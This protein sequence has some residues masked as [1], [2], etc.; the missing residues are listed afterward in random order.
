[1]MERKIS[2]AEIALRIEIVKK[3][4]A[5]KSTYTEV[6]PDSV[7]EFLEIVHSEKGATPICVQ[8]PFVKDDTVPELYTIIFD[9]YVGEKRTQELGVAR[10][11]CAGD[12]IVNAKV[13]YN[14]QQNH[15]AQK[16]EPRIRVDKLERSIHP[17]SNIEALAAYGKKQI[18]GT[19]GIE[20]GH[21]VIEERGVRTLF[22]RSKGITKRSFVELHMDTIDPCYKAVALE[23]AVNSAMQPQKIERITYFRP[24]QVT[25]PIAAPLQLQ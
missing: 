8:A 2:A 18:E 4:Y 17:V 9:R 6:F 22:R 25:Q 10:L 19:N 24:R 7:K 11:L 21:F 13:D 5:P 3:R 1:M 12:T 23:I 15:M 14:H 20:K 16:D